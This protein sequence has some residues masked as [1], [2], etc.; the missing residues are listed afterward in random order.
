MTG[1]EQV[2]TEATTRGG[3]SLHRGDGTAALLAK[4]P[5]GKGSAADLEAMKADLTAAAV[6]HQRHERRDRGGKYKDAKA[7]AEA[8]KATRDKIVAE[9]RLRSTRRRASSANSLRRGVAA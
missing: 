8:A 6:D 7:K 4:A 3:R 2:K 5:K 9:S 1:Q